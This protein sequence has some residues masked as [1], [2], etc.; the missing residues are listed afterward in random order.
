MKKGFSLMEMIFAIIIVGIV[1]GIA[2]PKL[3]SN[4]Q[5]ATVAA[6]KQDFNTFIQAI[7]TYHMINGKIER[8]SD[9]VV[10]NSNKWD[11]TD[12]SVEY[13]EEGNSCLKLV[14][15]NNIITT[16]IDETAGDICQKIYDDGIRANTFNLK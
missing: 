12:L 6:I 16:T 15:S 2:V 3:L 9:A 1:A 13:K 4:T 10:I 8:I 7:Q 5:D 14:V 11:T